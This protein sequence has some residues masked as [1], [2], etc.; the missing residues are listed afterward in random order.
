LLKPVKLSAPLAAAVAKKF[1][2]CILPSAN[3]VAQATQYNG[4]A[5]KANQPF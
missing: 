2:H 3:K 5:P 1:L 4:V